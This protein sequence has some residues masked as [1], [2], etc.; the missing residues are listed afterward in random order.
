MGQGVAKGSDNRASRIPRIA[1]ITGPHL[2]Q[3]VQY[4]FFSPL[5][6]SNFIDA[7]SFKDL[8]ARRIMLDEVISLLHCASVKGLEE[9]TWLH[10]LILPGMVGIRNPLRLLD[11]RA[12][13]ASLLA[14]EDNP[15]GKH[16]YARARLYAFHFTPFKRMS[17]IEW[18]NA[19]L[20]TNALFDQLA[21]AEY[22]PSFAHVVGSVDVPRSAWLEKAVTYGDAEGLAMCAAFLTGDNLERSEEV[23]QRVFELFSRAAELGH[24]AAMLRL[25]DMLWDRGTVINFAQWRARYICAT[26]RSD[27]SKFCKFL[28]GRNGFVHQDDA[29]QQ[30]FFVVGKEM[31]GFDL[32]WSEFKTLP[33]VLVHSIDVY[34]TVIHAARLASLCSLWALGLDVAHLLAVRVWNLRNTASVWY[35]LVK[36]GTDHLINSNRLGM[37]IPDSALP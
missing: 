24:P 27:T 34:L 26:G 28:E 2:L 16:Y 4:F 36:R 37:P 12:W 6:A 13:L 7:P 11:T 19:L 25:S 20:Q 5:K 32:I 30:I 21:V 31:E 1:S 17:P 10:N 8:T 22:A 18:D 15:R 14:Q 23:E 3:I 29:W 33:E 35:P 9:A